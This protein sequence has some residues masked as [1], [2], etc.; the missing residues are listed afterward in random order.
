[1]RLPLVLAAALVATVPFPAQTSTQ[2]SDAALKMD[3][4]TAAVTAH[5]PGKDD[6]P[7]AAIAP[8]TRGDLWAM[9]GE[10]RRQGRDDNDLLKRGAL[11]HADIAITRRTEV[12]YDLPLDPASGYL[13]G[14]GEYRGSM[15][16]TVHWVFGRHLLD[17]VRPSPRDDADVRLWYYATSAFLQAW[18]DYV[19]FQPH[20]ARARTI[21]PTDA[22]FA[23]Y[24][25][26]MHESFAEP[27]YQSA[28]VEPEVKQEINYRGALATQG[29][30]PPVKLVRSVNEERG[31]AAD[32]LRD[33]LRLDGTLHE[34]RI[35]LARLAGLRNA[36]REAVDEL[37][38]TLASPLPAPLEYWA[39]LF[40]GQSE[41]GLGRRDAARAAYERAAALYPGAQSPRLALS[42][43]AMETGDRAS[44]GASLDVLLLP[45][46][47]MRRHDPWAHYNGA[48]SPNADELVARLHKRWTR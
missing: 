37:R 46:G 25:G 6:A 18:Q 21:F 31:M 10:L 28:V 7:I 41:H 34:A 39:Q 27:R 16:R 20:L 12:G 40:L 35:R 8:W 4:W 5:V 44:A 1:M 15:G 23:L 33:A 11:L 9:F 24:E 17:A 30:T 32:L 36:H 42:Q 45:G 14:D 3:A 38:K 19:E 43:L 2:R 13:V 48:H 26:S 22:V 47:T 29:T